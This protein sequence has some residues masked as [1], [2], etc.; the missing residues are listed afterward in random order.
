MSV[1]RG[2]SDSKLS[3]LFKEKE[4]VNLDNFLPKFLLKDLKDEKKS[5]E[6]DLDVLEEKG[7][8]FEPYEAEDVSKYLNQLSIKEV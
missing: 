8:I 4:E 6:D 1:R 2:Q 7:T 3:K 5:V